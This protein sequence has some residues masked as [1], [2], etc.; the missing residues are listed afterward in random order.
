MLAKIAAGGLLFG[1]YYA[2]PS[3]LRSTRH[4]AD[5]PEASRDPSHCHGNP[6]PLIRKTSAVLH[7]LAFLSGVTAA[8]LGVGIGG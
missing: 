3:V 1:I 5:G 6:D 4:A 8:Y 2:A 7:A